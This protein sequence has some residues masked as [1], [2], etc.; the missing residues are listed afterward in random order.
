MKPL[1]YRSALSPGAVAAATEFAPSIVGVLALI[2]VAEARVGSTCGPYSPAWS[3]W[4]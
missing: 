3:C 4:R 1:G 2:A